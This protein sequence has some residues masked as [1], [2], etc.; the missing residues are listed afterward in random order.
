MAELAAREHTHIHQSLGSGPEAQLADQRCLP[1][2]DQGVIS[3]AALAH[4]LI[5]QLAGA[6]GGAR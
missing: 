5:G 1:A 4:G 3:A 2:L 6:D